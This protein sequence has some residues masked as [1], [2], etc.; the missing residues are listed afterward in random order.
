MKIEEIIN[1]PM[2]ALMGVI[3]CVAIGL[4]Y[5]LEYFWPV[6]AAVPKIFHSSESTKEKSSEELQMLACRDPKLPL[7][8]LRDVAKCDG[9]KNRKAYVACKGVVYDVSENAVYTQGGGYHCFTGKDATIALAKM[10]FELSGKPGWRQ[11]LNHEE[12]CVLSEWVTWYNDRYPKVGYLG[13]EYNNKDNPVE[14]IETTKVEFDIPLKDP[15]AKKN[16]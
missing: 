16:Q 11:S 6:H 1:E 4:A 12:L 7:L 3:V 2:L 5:A 13:E 15:K 14:G 10:E 9:Q 8:S